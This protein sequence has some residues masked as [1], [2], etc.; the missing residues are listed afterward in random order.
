MQK[1]IVA[2]SGGVDSS[3]SAALLKEQGYEVE[4]IF[5][6]NWSPETIQTLT[7]CPWE[8]DQK[9][10]EEVCRQLDIPFRS[11]NFEREYKEKVV[12][13]L[14]TEY[15]AGRTPNPDIMC[16]KE[17][18][19]RIF[20][21]KAAALGADLMATGHYVQVKDGKLARGTDP[22]KDQSYFLYTL[23]KE[24]LERSL[25]PVGGM[26]KSEVRR[27]A[28]SKNLVNKDKKDSQGICFIGHIDLKK[29]LMAQI[30]AQPGEVRL[31]PAY[32]EGVSLAARKE[33]AVLVGEHLGVMFHTLGERAGEVIN[34][35]AYKKAR[36]G[37]D[38]PPVYVLAK[39]IEQH[40]LYISEDRQDPHFF[41]GYLEVEDWQSTGGVF[42]VSDLETMSDL[43]CQIRY[44]QQ[45]KCEVEKIKLFE[46]G[47]IGIWLKEPVWATAAG[48]S[49]VVYSQNRFVVGGGIL[50][51]DHALP[52]N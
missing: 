18:K 50:T 46:D 11:V 28:A 36:A 34:N 12:D 41:S 2:M 13:Y 51:Q 38:V 20:L 19:F 21:E 17:I 39:N 31:L 44:Q 37:Q 10:A 16:N 27:I 4:G 49:A 52:R 24:Q 9:D 40:Y 23:N 35:G 22:Q 14:V 8:Q 6:K 47:K 7:D 30:T 25:F 42:Q 45:E 15:A 5:M 26:P 29:F 1:V 32:Q 48:Q 43:T 33:Q 3:V